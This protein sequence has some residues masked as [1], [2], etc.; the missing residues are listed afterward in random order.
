MGF[1]QL[2]RMLAFW[3]RGIEGFINQTESFGISKGAQPCSHYFSCL[4]LIEGV[5]VIDIP[6]Y[7]ANVTNL[8][9]GE[10]PNPHPSKHALI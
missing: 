6:F 3:G 9:Y 7:S 2:A 10:T 1:L 4:Q 8:D 5:C